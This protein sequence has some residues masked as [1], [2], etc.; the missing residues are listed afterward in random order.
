[1]LGHEIA[2]ILHSPVPWTAD[3]SWDHDLLT[4][5]WSVAAHTWDIVFPHGV[6]DGA[7]GDLVLCWVQ[8]VA[9]AILV[10]RVDGKELGV[11]DEADVIGCT[12]SLVPI[13][14]GNDSRVE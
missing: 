8:L 11:I 10:A 6:E 3:R 9:A 13:G 5:H 14:A 4:A 7:R 12:P 1:M 2:E